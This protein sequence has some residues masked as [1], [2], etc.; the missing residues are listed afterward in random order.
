MQKVTPRA[1]ALDVP[2]TPIQDN[3]LYDQD[4]ADVLEYAH[5]K[6][7]RKEKEFAM[8]QNDPLAL[9]AKNDAQEVQQR[10]FSVPAAVMV[11]PEA[12]L[13]SGSGGGSSS[14]SVAVLD[15]GLFVPQTPPREFVEIDSPRGSP[16]TRPR[17]PPPEEEPA[18]RARV[19]DAN[20]Q[21][22]NAI[23]REYE[24]RLTAVKRKYNEY[25]T[26]DDYTTE[27]NVQED[28]NSEEDELWSREN[29]IS[30]SDVPEALWSDHPTDSMPN[31]DPE[32]WVED[33]AD[34]VEINRLLKMGVL[35]LA[36]EFQGDITG[37]FTTKFVR[38][39]KLKDCDD[40]SG[41]C[42]KRWVRRSRHVAREFANTKRTDTF[43]AATGAH[44]ANLFQMK[45]LA[46][47]Q[48][49]KDMDVS[50]QPV[51]GCLDVKDAF[52]CA[53]QE[54]PTLAQFKGE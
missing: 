19:A 46:M 33:L 17:E 51:L 35:V 11:Q 16:G 15:P 25:F 31:F 34:T 48:S 4:A 20:K 53:E 36:Q 18:K 26:M 30:F 32:G 6:K 45:Y 54:E 38:D 43:S 47:K 9:K 40:G 10:K 39:W 27:L 24:S 41:K 8:N 42:N 14:A 22:I 1:L 12:N 49:A 13:A 23:K 2:P 3:P 5:Q 28:C 21:R 44:A 50:Y 29:E 37:K 7:R 52:L